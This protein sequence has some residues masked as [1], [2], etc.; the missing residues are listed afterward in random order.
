MRKHANSDPGKNLAEKKSKYS[1]Q[2]MAR[3]IE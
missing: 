1:M 3:K 2:E